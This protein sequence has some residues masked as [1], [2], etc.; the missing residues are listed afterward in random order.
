MWSRV[1]GVKSDQILGLQE[2]WVAMWNWSQ[3]KG[4]Q[5]TSLYQ[6]CYAPRALCTLSPTLPVT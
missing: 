5:V 6:V 4:T 3:P 1:L 2:D